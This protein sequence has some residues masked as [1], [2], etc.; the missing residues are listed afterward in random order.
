[1]IL[2]TYAASTSNRHLDYSQALNWRKSI[3]KKKSLESAFV[4][5]SAQSEGFPCGLATDFLT[6]WL[7]E[8]I[9]R[10]I[11]Y[12]WFCGKG[13]RFFFFFPFI[14]RSV[15]SRVQRV[16]GGKVQ[17]RKERAQRSGLGKLRGK[18]KGKRVK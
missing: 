13:G 7:Q 17:R 6:L 12:L 18:G 2:R 5:P 14:L 1:M 9:D 15:I 8:G 10:C 4:R 11:C 3:D 16:V